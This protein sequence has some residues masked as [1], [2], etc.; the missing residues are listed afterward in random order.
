MVSRASSRISLTRPS[1]ASAASTASSI[2]TEGSPARVSTKS[3]DGRARDLG[4]RRERPDA[5]PRSIWAL[6]LAV[7]E[8][9]AVPL[10][11]S[12]LHDS[13]VP[14]HRGARHPLDALSRRLPRTARLLCGGP[15]RH[16]D[17]VSG[18]QDPGLP[19]PGQPRNLDRVVSLRSRGAN[20]ELESV[21]AHEGTP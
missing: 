5:E 9:Q 12:L 20:H 3:A 21:R 10:A 19:S 14:Q 8:P 1:D 13:G 2:P 15:R 4:T 6:F 18:P 11:R 7:V 17:R 16:L